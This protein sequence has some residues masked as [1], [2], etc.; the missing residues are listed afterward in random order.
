MQKNRQKNNLGICAKIRDATIQRGMSN[1]ELARRS[2]VSYR[3]IYNIMQGDAN[4]RSST[5]EKLCN[6]LGC[7][8]LA[9]PPEKTEEKSCVKEGREFY[10]PEKSEKKGADEVRN[11]FKILALQFGVDETKLKKRVLEVIMKMM[12]D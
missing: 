4:L 11:V 1:A 9:E 7:D 3:L 2:G 10:F 6:V 5:I 8:L 12:E